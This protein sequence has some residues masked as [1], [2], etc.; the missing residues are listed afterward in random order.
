MLCFRS[1]I[2]RTDDE[3]T[4]TIVTFTDMEVAL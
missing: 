4:D 1:A 2:G 3:E